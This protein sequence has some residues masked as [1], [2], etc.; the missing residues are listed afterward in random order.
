MMRRNGFTLIELLVVISIIA[1]L[2]AILMPALN[3][4]KE[5]AMRVVCTTNLKG[6]GT[7]QTVYANDYKGKF[8]VQ[9]AGRDHR[10]SFYTS[11]FDQPKKD[12]KRDIGN[13]TVGASLYLL[14][15]EADVTTKSFVCPSSEQTP[16]DGENTNIDDYPDLVDLW[17]FGSEPIL[18]QGSGPYG[19]VSYAYHMPYTAGGGSPGPFAATGYRSAAFALMADKNPYFDSKLKNLQA[20]QENYIGNA[21]F[22]TNDTSYDKT[23]GWDSI[24]KWMLRIGNSRNHS[25]DGQSVLFAGGHASYETRPDVGQKHDNIYL[26]WAESKFAAQEAHI[27]IGGLMGGSGM[28][29]FIRHC[30]PVSEEDSVLVNDLSGR[31]EEPFPNLR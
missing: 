28:P 23:Q 20:N 1:M 4:V 22:I 15:R 25:R 5:I 12:W 21:W 19:H 6:L 24:E 27:R 13:I 7:A 2:L 18:G 11:D 3:K 9:G 26:P 8:T 16:Y 17:D 31:G 14:V 29:R 10:L 30:L